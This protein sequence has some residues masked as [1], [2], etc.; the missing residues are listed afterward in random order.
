MAR[1]KITT[2]QYETLILRE[3]ETRLKAPQRVLNEDSKEVTLGMALL[4][5]LKLSGLNKELAEKAIADEAVINQIKAT[6]EDRYKTK[7]LAKSFGEKGLANSDYFFANNADKIIDAFNKVAG[8][9]QVGEGAK[10]NL[11]DLDS[12][13]AKE[14]K[15]KKEESSSDIVAI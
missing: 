11:L 8:D 2:Q 6:L 4:S 14:Y 3:Q 12:K 10:L 7:D 15:D 13:L 5:G 9:K 1:I